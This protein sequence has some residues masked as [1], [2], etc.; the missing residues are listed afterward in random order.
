M[1]IVPAFDST[2]FISI[3]ARSIMSSHSSLTISLP[4]L[5]I[6]PPEVG[7]VVRDRRVGERVQRERGISPL[8]TVFIREPET[9]DIGLFQSPFL[10]VSVT[11]VHVHCHVGAS[12]DKDVF[13]AHCMP[14]FVRGDTLKI[15]H[16]KRIRIHCRVAEPETGIEE[17]VGFD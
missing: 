14:K 15:H 8:P 6:H 7:S 13:Q 10:Y 9:S 4:C 17:Y 12:F 11:R 2:D 5:H 16:R 1:T 3:L